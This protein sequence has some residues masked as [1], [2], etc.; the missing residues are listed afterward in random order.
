MDKIIYKC[1]TREA[2]LQQ[3]VFSNNDVD[4][5]VRTKDTAVTG[6][7]FNINV[8]GLGFDEAAM[9]YSVGEWDVEEHW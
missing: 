7:M 6:Y 1:D 9:S 2:G 4:I 5:I 8:E 3:L